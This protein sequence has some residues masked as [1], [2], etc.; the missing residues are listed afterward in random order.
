LKSGKEPVILADG[1]LKGPPDMIDTLSK[2]GTSPHKKVGSNDDLFSPN[3]PLSNNFTFEDPESK[4]MRQ[5]I[6]AKR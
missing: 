3:E 2:K 4:Y 6:E 5:Q 1:V